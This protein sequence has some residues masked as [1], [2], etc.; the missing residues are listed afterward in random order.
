[1]NAVYFKGLWAN[2]F[3]EDVTRDQDFWVSSNESIKV[4]M[5]Y[6]KAKFGYFIHRELGATML[7]MN[8]Q[9][10]IFIWHPYGIMPVNDRI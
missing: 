4:P 5:M 1:M 2:Q 6:K 9:V 3:S 7:A 8:Y 10:S